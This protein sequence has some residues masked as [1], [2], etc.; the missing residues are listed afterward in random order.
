MR[1]AQ[2]K[3][4]EERHDPVTRRCGHR[5]GWLGGT[6]R[7]KWMERGKRRLGMDLCSKKDHSD[8][9]VSHIYLHVVNLSQT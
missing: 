5:L 4:Y 8:I 1:L 6:R 9:N 2:L 7:G 3:G